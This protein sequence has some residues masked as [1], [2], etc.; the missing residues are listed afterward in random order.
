MK[1]FVTHPLEVPGGSESGQKLNVQATILPGVKYV[2]ALDFDASRSIVVTGNG[3]Y[4]L[5]P[6][7]KTVA[8][9]KS[10]SLTG[11]V[12]PDSTRPT[13]WAIAGTDTSTTIADTTGGI[14]FRY[15]IPAAYLLRFVPSDTT[16]RETTLTN[17]VVFAGENTDLGTV[18]LRK[19]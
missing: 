5:K 13:V 11:V 18:V 6:V 12:V 4:K 14:R 17:V 7:I 3:P 1:N 2:L 10:G 8:I 19:K 15:L 16:C 9:A